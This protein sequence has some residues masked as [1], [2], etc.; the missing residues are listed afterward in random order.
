VSEGVPPTI[1]ATLDVWTWRVQEGEAGARLDHFLRDQEVGPSRSQL[2]RLIDGGR[3][4][5]DGAPARPS[6]RLRT[7]QL[8]ELEIPP[9]EPFLAEPEEMS[10]DIL[11][12]DDDVVVVNKPQGLVVHPAPGHPRGTLVNGL[13]FLCRTEGGDPMRPGIVHRLDKDT[14]GVMVV[15]RNERAHVHLGRQFHDHTVERSYLA[16]VAGD[17]PDR[18][19]WRTLHGRREGDRRLFSSRVERGRSAVSLF[20]T[21]E[22]FPGAAMLAVTLRTG[23]T[24]QVRVH[25]GDHGLPVLGDPWYGPRHLS[26]ALAGVNRSLP[27]QALHARILGF[28]HPATGEA[29]R[30]E[31][32]PPR[33]FAAALVGLR[34][35]KS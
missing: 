16:L 12:V 3:A 20:E 28:A 30:F 19:E 8:I 1:D 32:A 25:C 10:L 17:P 18:G 33:E 5:I 23:R 21:L 11:H 27:G 24:H 26:A 14:S 13:A 29:M 4:R 7:G 22:R 6:K 15:A 31:V 34:G 2:K 35:M 9:P